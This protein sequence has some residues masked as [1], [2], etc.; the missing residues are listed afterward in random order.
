MS[1]TE[2]LRKANKWFEEKGWKP[3]TF[4]R[5]TW[6]AYLSGKHGLLNA[7]T[8][9]GK[10]LALWVPIVLQLMEN[11]KGKPVKGLR[12]IW[13]TPLKSLSNEIKLATERFAHEMGMNFSVGI[14]NGDT[15]ASE[16]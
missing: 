10:T 3:S 8:G 12:A 14:R 6:K 7:P 1:K 4:Q 5:S 13:I 15:S 9:S 16:R 11:Q 2:A